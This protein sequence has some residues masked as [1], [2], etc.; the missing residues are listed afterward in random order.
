MEKTNKSNVSPVPEG[1]HTVTPY[2]AVENATRF[3]QF[4]E[5]AFGGKT[6]FVMKHE[7][8]KVMHA[9]MQIGNSRIMIC[10]IMENTPAQ[11]A[12]LYLYVDNSDELFKKAQK[13]NATVTF[14]MENQFYGDRVGALKDEWGNT[15]WIATQV[16]EVEQ[17]ELERRGKIV[18]KE[19]KE[20]SQE[21]HA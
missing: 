7:G 18:M 21:V 3:M 17:N 19:R 13:E 11:P 9:T 1:F 8:D 2:L 15:W 6:V 14:P 12:I 10:D 16:E 4:V 20:K 5:K